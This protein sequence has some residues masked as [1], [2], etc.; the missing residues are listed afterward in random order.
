MS[1]PMNR[2]L[3]MCAVR[4]RIV[5]SEPML[6]VVNLAAS[7]F[8]FIILLVAFNFLS[9]SSAA[10]RSAG[11]IVIVGIINHACHLHHFVFRLMVEFVFLE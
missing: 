2:V 3:S 7:L 11:R 8:A 1:G 5:F 4:N 9:I 10:R 6:V